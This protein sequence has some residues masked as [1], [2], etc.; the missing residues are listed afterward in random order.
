MLL[1]IL[2]VISEQVSKVMKALPWEPEL[3]PKASNS[4]ISRFLITTIPSSAYVFDGD[5]NITLQCA[6]KH[7]CES[8]QSNFKLSVPICSGGASVF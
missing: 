6:G 3:S 2:T 4:G 5:I 8:L 7:I 1:E